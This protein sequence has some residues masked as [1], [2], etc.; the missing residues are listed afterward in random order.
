MP[1]LSIASRS[2]PQ[3]KA[4]PCHSSGSSPHAAITLRMDHA[5]AEH[6]HPASG[7]ADHALAL[8]QGVADI[9]LGRRL[10]EREVA[11]AQA[12]HDVVALEERLEEGLERPLE[13]AE[14][15]ALV[16]HQPLDLVEHR[17]VR[18][19]AVRPIDAAGRDDADRR[20]LRQHRADLHGTGVGAQQHPAAAPSDGEPCPPAVLA[21]GRSRRCRA[22]PAPDGS[23]EC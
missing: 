9:D 23:R 11:G 6:L 7:P 10:G 8:H 12:Q 3:P 2:M 1:Y 13:V 16:D 17:R 19:V 4:K 14:R 22:S 18:R 15:D 20:F 5:A 21:C